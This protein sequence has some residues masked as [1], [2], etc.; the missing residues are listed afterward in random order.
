LADVAIGH[1]L[2]ASRLVPQGPLSEQLQEGLES[3]S[4]IELAKRITSNQQ[5]ITVDQAYQRIR[6]H[7]RRNHASIRLVSEAIVAVGLRV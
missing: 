2:N 6:R 7:A 1:V 4:V 5:G 3:R